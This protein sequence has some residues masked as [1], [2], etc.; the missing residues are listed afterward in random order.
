M[1]FN[2]KEVPLAP[3][4]ELSQ[5]TFTC[6]QFPCIVKND[7]TKALR[8]IG[9][10]SSVKKVSNG[11]SKF[12]ELR[13]RP[14]D[15]MSHPTY[16]DHTPTN[17][18]LLRVRRMRDPQT[19]KFKIE[20]A[21]IVGKVDHTIQFRG[22]V[23][24]QLLQPKVKLSS[25]TEKI[26][27]KLEDEAAI[28]TEEPTS[29]EEEFTTESL[30]LPPPIFS[31]FDMSAEYNFRGNPASTTL[32][33]ET[34]S[35]TVTT[36]KL[37]KPIPRAPKSLIIEFNSTDPVPDGP[38][39]NINTED[40]EFVNKLKQFFET[41]P[42][43]SRMALQSQFESRRH[44]AQLKDKLPLVAYMFSSGPWRNLWIKFS[45][46]PRTDRKYGPYQMLDF[47]IQTEHKEYIKERKK[48]KGLT[49][50]SED[51]GG[52]N[53]LRRQPKR[54]TQ[55]HDDLRTF[56]SQGASA[57]PPQEEEDTS[58]PNSSYIFDSI[59]VQQQT[60][61]QLCDIQLPAVQDIVQCQD[62]EE[63]T[64]VEI[65]DRSRNI[66]Y[67][68]IRILSSTC[69]DKSGWYTNEALSHVRILMKQQVDEWIKHGGDEEEDDE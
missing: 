24:F 10:E 59:P 17:N 53:M 4:K 1:Q 50:E 3:S 69:D 30:N 29:I 60:F 40:D 11:E 66:V 16:G 67:K 64:P 68:N 44:L 46:D 13:F 65:E 63:E 28:Q 20:S 49:T 54:R 25:T 12:L 19:R 33:V 22:M 52:V 57:P 8:M 43:W 27:I 23:D 47:R 35:G 2:A 58:N 55:T 6:V 32:V 41:R 9:G 36:R 45:I 31:R 39:D 56:M 15:P 37:K 48:Q 5:T 14:G 21:N 62:L 7:P 42:I 18:L 26:K 51:F 61:Y 38:K 34:D